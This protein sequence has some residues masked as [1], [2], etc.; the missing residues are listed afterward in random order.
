[1]IS[2][3]IEENEAIRK[4][5]EGDD[6]YIPSSEYMYLHDRPLIRPNFITQIQDLVDVVGHKIMKH[7]LN[8]KPVDRLEDIAIALGQAMDGEMNSTKANT[9]VMELRNLYQHC[10]NLNRKLK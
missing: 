2:F 3:L 10:N 8:G 9:V 7:R 4:F 6:S 1:M 5:L